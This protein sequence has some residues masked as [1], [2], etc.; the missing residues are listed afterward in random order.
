MT[1]D[2]TAGVEAELLEQ[3]HRAF[4]LF[5][6]D[7]TLPWRTWTGYGTLNWGGFEWLGLGDALRISA[8][9]ET[10][11]TE[12]EGLT[13]ELSGVDPAKLAIALAEPVQGKDI[14]VW[15]GFMDENN[16][17]IPEPYLE[18]AGTADLMAPS[19]DGRTAT[20]KLTVET[21]WADTAPTSLRYTHQSQQ[22]LYP[23]DVFFEFAARHGAKSPK[24][25]VED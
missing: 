24:W 10:I 25:L 2:L 18:Y 12:S 20:I 6:A 9:E 16:L 21:A 15:F 4:R 14:E 1:R 11:D 5:Y 7:F 23:G 13:V 22:A 3:S 19:E 8:S 17:V